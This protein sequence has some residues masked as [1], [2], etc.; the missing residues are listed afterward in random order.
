MKL[1]FLPL[2]LACILLVGCGA[3]ED[4]GALG[5]LGADMMEQAYGIAE[6]NN[7]IGTENNEGAKVPDAE[8]NAPEDSEDVQEPYVLTFEAPTVD[9]EIMTSECF[10]QSKLTMLNVWGTYCGP[11][12]NE[13][14]YLGEIA[15]AYKKDDF[16]MIGIICDV[17]ED[18]ADEDVAYAKSLIEQ[19]GANYTHLLLSES[20]YSNLVS[21]VTAVPTT[22]FVNQKGEVLGYVVGA[23][24]KE[25]W[26]EL[27][28]DLL[29]K[30]E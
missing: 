23:L 15:T 21:V 29:A 4:T 14:P 7:A 25:N 17:E 30:S 26:E 5:S 22:F 12:L 6:D 18:G 24:E 10:G 8:A 9:G 20:L 19:T 13:M 1:K 28:H 16:Q 2:L 27:I 11:C 3:E